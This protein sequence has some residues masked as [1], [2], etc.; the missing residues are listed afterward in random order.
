MGRVTTLPGRDGLYL[1]W[2]DP[3]RRRTV[4]RRFRGTRAEA[5]R[6]L[7]ELQTQADRQALGLGGER[8]NHVEIDQLIT[9]WH[10]AL[11][12]V[13]RPRTWESY[14]LGL[15]TV[16][17]WLE[18]RCR[19]RLVSD[20]R[21]DDINAFK[22]E[23]LE[24]GIARPLP[25]D[26]PA[27]GT[28][29]ATELAE[30]AGVHVNT[31]YRWASLGCPRRADRRF[32]LA[33]VRDWHAARN[34]PTPMAER[35]VEILVGALVEMLRWAERTERIARNPLKG[36]KPPKGEP[37]RERLPLTEWEI[38]KLLAAS[39]PDLADIWRVFLATGLRA[40]ELTALEWR[41]IDVEQRRI[42]VRADTSKS[43]RTRY[44]PMSD[45]VLIIL[46]RLRLRVAERP[47]RETARRLVFVNSAG[48]PWRDGLG[49][50]FHRIVQAA[51]LRDGI[52][53][54]TLR[55]TFG[56]YVAG[57]ADFRTLQELLGHS[58]AK[59]T[60]VYLHGLQP[61]LRQ[62]VEA[63]EPLLG[64]AREIDTARRTRAINE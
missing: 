1:E 22:V 63:V 39:P 42:R 33:A 54:H 46:Q 32:D 60:E 28:A 51:G 43:R 41:D 57:T 11:T 64:H 26:I 16:L 4:R 17:N 9:A 58:T 15:R 34:A 25:F 62:A 61:R 30:I 47:K 2:W 24:R 8:T 6:A 5:R 7:R 37:R 40:G 55:H 29:T 45:R 56:S 48:G 59:A 23:A 20:L 18:A 38:A 44:V 21:L 49:K 10:A 3:I 52:D 36:W 19:P 53:L 27:R 31:V 12:G 35:T 50:R 13:V 14:E